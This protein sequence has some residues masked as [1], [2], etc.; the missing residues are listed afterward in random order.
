MK[1][2]IIYFLL[3]I[4]LIFCQDGYISGVIMDE[5]NTPLPGANIYFYGFN[6]GTAADMEGNFKVIN[7]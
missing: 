5:D 3:C 6:F 2:F 4:S 7:L 1:K